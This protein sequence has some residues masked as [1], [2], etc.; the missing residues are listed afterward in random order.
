M[1]LP[2][3]PRAGMLLVCDLTDFKPPEMDK[4]RPVIIISPRL[5]HRSDVVTVVPTSTQKPRHSLP[6]CVQLSKNYHP[7]EADQPAPWAKCDMLMNLSAERL[8]GFKVG[9]RKFDHPIVSA[10]DLERV[11]R[12]VL[13]ALGFGNLLETGESPK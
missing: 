1:P 6:F 10:E 12:G 2:F 13:H 5:P 9:R 7:T 11:R 4:H 3:Y 8:N